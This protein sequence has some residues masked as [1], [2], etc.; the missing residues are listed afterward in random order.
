MSS[1]LLSCT[2]SCEVIKIATTPLL[3]FFSSYDSNNLSVTFP[4]GLLVT[5][6]EII[7]TAGKG[8][9]SAYVFILDKEKYLKTLVKA[10]N[11]TVIDSN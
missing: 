10:R 3:P 6:N 2:T 8:D 4:S 11:L 1:L 9:E 7:I 5:D